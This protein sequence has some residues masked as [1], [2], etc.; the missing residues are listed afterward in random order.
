MLNCFCRVTDRQ[1][2]SIMSPAYFNNVRID[3][4]KVFRVGKLSKKDSIKIKEDSVRK[5]VDSI[6]LREVIKS[7]FL[8]GGGLLTKQTKYND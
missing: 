7:R 6:K 3:E 8:N 1:I 2:K 4:P 5:K